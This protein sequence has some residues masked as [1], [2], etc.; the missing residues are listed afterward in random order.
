MHKTKLNIE[1][2]EDATN[3]KILWL[4]TFF[5]L[6]YIGLPVLYTSSRNK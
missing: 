5:R 6:K 3:V 2:I 1:G 4:Y